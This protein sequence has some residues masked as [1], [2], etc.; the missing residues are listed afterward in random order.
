M[1]E[2]QTG[3]GEIATLVPRTEVV[4]C[5]EVEEATSAVIDQHH[6]SELVEDL[7]RLSRCTTHDLMVHPVSMA[8]QLE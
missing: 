2:D 8:L 4:S 1:K 5:H 7:V 3:S 6:R